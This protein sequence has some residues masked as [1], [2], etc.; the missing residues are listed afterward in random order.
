LVPVVNGISLVDD[1]GNYKFGGAE[2]T[3]M[4]C[5]VVQQ[6]K[7]TVANS[8]VRTF[9]ETSCYVKINDNKEILGKYKYL[10]E[11]RYKIPELFFTPQDKGFEPIQNII[12]K[13][14]SQQKP[15][16]QIEL[17]NNIVLSG[18][19]TLLKN[20]DKRVENELNV[21]FDGVTK[22][23]LFDASSNLET[24]RKYLAFKGAQKFG[25]L[26]NFNDFC[27]SKK[28][29]L[30]YGSSVLHKKFFN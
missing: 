18:G 10:E 25:S 6:K 26:D 22:V 19:T 24:Q 3:N 14:I 8:D 4:L 2:I 16:V 13:Q 11:E 21:F 15:E 1:I 27:V 20:F 12:Y 23:K 5:D 29:F 9:K 17:L 30:E 28:E 7:E